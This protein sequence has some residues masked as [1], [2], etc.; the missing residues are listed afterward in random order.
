MISIVVPSFNRAD[1]FAETLD[2]VSHQDSDDFECI[3][4]DDG[5]TDNSMDLVRSYLEKDSRFVLVERDRE[6]KGACTCRNIGVERAKGD[7]VM[8]LDT[9]DLLEP[10]AISQR[11]S[12]MDRNPD[13]DFALFPSLVF[14][15]KPHDLRKWWNREDDRT[16][17]V[18]QLNMDAISQG[19]AVIF[20]KK[21]FTELGMWDA[22]LAVW[23]DIDLF[24]RAYTGGYSFGTF[25]NIA[26]DL[27]IRI[28]PGS[29]SRHNFHSEPKRRS[30]EQVTRS[31]VAAIKSA[32]LD[33]DLI[34]ME[35]IFLDSLSSM[36]VNREFRRGESFIAWALEEDLI[37]PSKASVLE[38]CILI[39][40][41]RLYHLP[42]LK[43][44]VNNTLKA[45]TRPSGIAMTSYED[46][47][48]TE[49]ESSAWLPS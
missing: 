9:D 12:V 23:Q 4:V 14:E 47:P 19:T 32:S 13:L 43:R 31:A 49:P 22:S 26:P 20:R 2:S 48:L 10:F 7:L 34:E 24:I 5:S 46:V 37:T 6:P 36:I 11:Q 27:H 30:R 3:V 29:I 21:M 8:F 15:H 28:N 38:R 45:N 35:G 39:Y 33:R 44:W 18:R 41:F 16:P 25:F 42:F 17:L 40:R 1:I